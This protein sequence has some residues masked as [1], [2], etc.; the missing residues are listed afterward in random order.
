MNPITL[1]TGANGF[2]GAYVVR[3]LL[4]L[5]RR[6][7]VLVRR[8]QS[9]APTIRPRVE[10]AAGD[11][12]DPDALAS[13]VRNVDTILH[14]AG[15][16]KAWSSDPD[17]FVAVNVRAV[18]TL[19]DCAAMERVRRLVHV[20]SIVTLP[21]FRTGRLGRADNLV[22]P[23]ETTK[24]EGE[25][26]VEEYAASTGHACIVH[27]TRVYGPGPLNDA[28]GATKAVALYLRGQLRVRLDDGDVLGNYVHTEDVA[29]GILLA[30]QRGRRGG[31][32][33]LGGE[34]ISFRDL[35]E[36]A[37]EISGIRHRL[38]ALPPRVAL[39][40]ARTAELWGRLG[41]HP[42]IT[43]GWVRLYLEDWRA[44]SAA[45]EQDL[46]YRWRPL[47][48]GLAETIDWLSLRERREAA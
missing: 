6:V 16:A 22:T 21:P 18:R 9:L 32:Y 15:C 48:V 13:A 24:L 20:S 4:T 30:A 10:I 37:S 31:H 44:S 12:R 46:R 29:Q 33:V 3:R 47:R 14:L 1:V 2:I 27:P 17:E 40:V 8:P 36:L 34:D 7:R 11:I 25:R 19:L 23:Y 38:I 43:P 5:G 28:N 42:F 35:L 26:L 45:A 41:G 39:A